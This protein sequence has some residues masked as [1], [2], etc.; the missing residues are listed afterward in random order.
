MAETHAWQDQNKHVIDIPIYH[1]TKHIHIHHQSTRKMHVHMN[2]YLTSLTLLRL[3]TY[4]SMHGHLN[5][6]SWKNK[7]IFEEKP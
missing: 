7:E 5:V 1:S 3:S 2:A 6:F 4:V